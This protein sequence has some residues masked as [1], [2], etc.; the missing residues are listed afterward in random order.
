MHRAA[1]LWGDRGTG[2]AITRVPVETTCLG[3]SQEFSHRLYPL[4]SLLQLSHSDTLFC[5]LSP[6]IHSCLPAPFPTAYPTP[7]VTNLGKM[8]VSRGIST[9]LLPGA[10]FFTDTLNAL[11]RPH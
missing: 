7:L 6:P 10:L 5:H 8:L 4:L 1:G 2:M 9:P 11:G 3:T